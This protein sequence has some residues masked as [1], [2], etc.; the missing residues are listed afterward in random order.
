M[1]E[2]QDHIDLA[3]EYA[4]MLTFTGFEIKGFPGQEIYRLSQYDSYEVEKQD[5]YFKIAAKDFFDNNLSVDDEFTYSCLS[6]TYTFKIMTWKNNITGWVTLQV[7][8][9]EVQSV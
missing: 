6:Q 7:A 4:E 5:F 2:T 3:L 8:F 1:Q 9:V